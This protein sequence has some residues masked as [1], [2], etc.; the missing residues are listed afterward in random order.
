MKKRLLYLLFLFAM[1]ITFAQTNLSWQ[2]YFSYNQIKAVSESPTAIHAASENALFSK[3]TNTNIIKTTTT[4]DGLSGETITALYYSPTSNKTIVGYQNGLLTVINEVDG[5]ILKVV[6]I[7][8]KNLPNGIKRINSFMEFGGIVYVS[9]DFGIVQFNLATSKFGDTYFIGD[10]G[11]EIKVTQTAVYKGFIYAATSNGIRKGDITNPNLVDYKQWQLT[12]AGIWSGITAFGT[13]LYAVN[14]SGYVHKYDSGAKTFNGF[15]ALPE[16]TSDFRST[17]DYFVIT[18]PN[19]VL[20]YNKQLLVQREIKRDQIPEVN[21]GFSCATLIDDAIHI[22]TSEN[23]LITTPLLS[24]TSFENLTPS[25]PLRNSIFSMQATPTQLWA[26]YGDYNQFYN[27]YPK[28][29]FGISKFSGLGWLNIPYEKV[30]G[31]KSLIRVAVDLNNENNVYVGSFDAGM[32]KI[33]NEIP[34]FLYN[35]TNSPLEAIAN[36]NDVWVNGFAFDKSGDLWLNNSQVEN[37]IKVLKT[38]G[39]WQSFSTKSIVNEYKKIVYGRISIDKNGTKWLATNREGIIGFNEKDNI[40]KKIAPGTDTGNLPSNDARVTV[41]DNNDQ[42]WIGTTKGLRVLSNVNSFL[43]ENQ[44]TTKPII[45]FENDLA[46]ELMYDQFITDIEVDGANNK[47]I[48]TADAGIFMVSPDGQET[49]YHF[50][51]NNSPLPSNI[52]NDITINSSSGEVFIATSKGLISFKGIATS[53]SEN[54]NNVFVYPNPVRPNYEGTVKI[55][56]LLNKSNVKITDIAGNLVY[57]AIS[58]GGT[59]EWDT[60]AFGKYKVASGV[61]MIFI[62]GQDGAETKVKKVMII[63]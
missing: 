43:T 31:A 46:Q 45:I 14:T 62:S 7:I 13:E 36:T 38:S 4:V 20:I 3:D 52:I 58:E 10:N 5:S 9:T 53:A 15:L 59:I 16:S 18:T 56:G 30:L 47:W 37:G 57:E 2:G 27:P 24:N 49:K 33:E 23:G 60:T 40:F 54:L 25:G 6:D 50:T 39:T 22:G 44:L 26:V 32:L 21:S 28:D 42:L 61:Y 41:V 29:S 17:A 12:T 34:T 1:Q 63:R 48:G 51:I 35:P 19:S 55:N 8:N 11:S